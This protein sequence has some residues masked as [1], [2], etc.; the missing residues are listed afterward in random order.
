M[1]VLAAAPGLMLMANMKNIAQLQVPAD[2]VVITQTTAN[3]TAMPSPATAPAGWQGAYTL[4]MLLAA[5]NTAGRIV[6]GAVSDR[7]GRTQTMVLAFLLQA[8]N[9]C[10]FSWYSSKML[11]IGGTAVAGLCYGSIFTLMPATM[12]DYYGLKNLG[13][14]YGFLF[15]AFGVAGTTGS[16]LGGRVRDLTGNYTNAYFIVAGMLA[17][18]VVLAFITH[19]PR[20]P[21]EKPELE[22]AAV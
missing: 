9:L 5:F 4:V 15:T 1:F 12:A 11:L 17:L 14:N 20:V 10:L 21:A 7:I 16:L 18:A 8:I 3:A 6:G 2:P 13:V 19:P 22:K